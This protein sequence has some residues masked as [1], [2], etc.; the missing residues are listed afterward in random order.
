V[1]ITFGLENRIL[2]DEE[3]VDGGEEELESLPFASCEC[4]ALPLLVGTESVWGASSAVLRFFL[5]LDGATGAFPAI[6]EVDDVDETDSSWIDASST[7]FRFIR[8][9]L[10]LS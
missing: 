9:G 8:L 5:L 10:R 2:K 6:L 4:D 3:G 7:A 1:N